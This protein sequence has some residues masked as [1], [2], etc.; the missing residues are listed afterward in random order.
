MI[1]EE[2]CDTI[3]IYAWWHSHRPCHRASTRPPRLRLHRSPVIRPT[4]LQRGDSISKGRCRE[5][6]AAPYLRSHR[7]ARGRWSRMAA[8]GTRGGPGPACSVPESHDEARQVTGEQRFGAFLLSG[9]NLVLPRRR[10]L[11]RTGEG[12]SRIGDPPAGYD[13]RT[14][15]GA[16]GTSKTPTAVAGAASLAQGLGPKCGQVT[17][18]RHRRQARPDGWQNRVVLGGW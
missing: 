1:L 12:S 14:P 11:C 4:G 9:V 8:A 2:Q 3:R 5:S 15:P 6:R 18:S 13:T 17:H 10:V 7:A 16:H